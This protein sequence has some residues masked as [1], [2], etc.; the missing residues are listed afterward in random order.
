MK[1][2]VYISKARVQ[3]ALAIPKGLSNIFS[4]ARKNNLSRQLTGVLSYKNGHYLQVIEGEN[5][6]VDRMYAAIS[7][8]QRHSDV[9]TILDIKTRGR[10]FPLWSMRLT[11]SV[12]KYAEFQTLMGNNAP[13]IERLSEEKRQLLN[14]FYNQQGS[15]TS[16]RET[17]QGKSL[18]LTG[19]PD[20]TI[21]NQ[22]PTVIDISAKLLNKTH[23]FDSL[24]FSGNYG[25]ADQ[26]DKILRGFDKLGILTV[27]DAAQ[28]EKN[29]IPVVDS[30]GFYSKMRH[31][32]GLREKHGI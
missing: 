12:A 18:K 22:T 6:A 13:Y 27:R 30:V 7:T 29:E 24:A 10:F 20:F 4:Q 28:A 14:V 1:C 5:E 16:F 2:I 11:D 32:L 31:F 23:T 8:D 21:I 9:T 26:I 15:A 17:Y 19:W 3:H 25:T